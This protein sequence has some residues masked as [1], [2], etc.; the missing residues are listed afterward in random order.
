MPLKRTETEIKVA[1]AWGEWVAG[2]GEWHVFGGLTYAPGRRPCTTRYR[3]PI[4]PS[5]EVVLRHVRAWLGESQRRLG[6]PI[7]AGVIA[8]EHHKNGWP[9]AHPLLRLAGG[10]Q[11]RDFITV[12]Q[13]WFERHGYAKLEKPRDQLDVA[14]YAA[15]YLA[16][17]LSRGDVLF[18]PLRGSLAV[19][20]LATPEL[21][22][23][24][25]AQKRGRP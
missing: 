5:D 9:H 10:L 23:S 20:Q 19:H 14:S 7:E 16:K 3:E 4:A 2:M 15:K 8:I 13:T 21:G 22:A 17:D 12:G 18:W 24:R 25:P 11:E 6:R 1:A